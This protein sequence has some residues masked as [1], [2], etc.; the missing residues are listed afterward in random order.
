MT[1]IMAVATEHYVVL[2]SDRR[3]TVRDPRNRELKSQQDTDTKASFS[4][5][6]M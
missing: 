4:I 6:A 1:L 3:I 2:L 5:T